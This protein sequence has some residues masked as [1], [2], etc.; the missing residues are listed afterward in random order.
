M[1]MVVVS[2]THLQHEKLEIP[3]GDIIV[4][5]G[6]FS[7]S[8]KSSYA[9]FDWYSKL[10]FKYKILVAGNHDFIFYNNDSEILE[11][12]LNDDYGII[13]L[14]DKSVTIE[15]IKFHGSP[16]TVKFF[17]FAFMKSDTELKEYWDKIPLDTQV[18][19]THGPQFEV[20][21]RVPGNYGGIKHTGSKT[22][23]YKMRELR[24]LKYHL[25]GH[26]HGETNMKEISNSTQSY[27]SVNAA[28]VYD[29][30]ENRNNQVKV[31]I[32][33]NI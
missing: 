26:I 29:F 17:N 14:Q 4:H 18:L 3:D 22:L 12:K 19:I 24:N 21:D 2:D 8:E 20:L 13:Y 25:F 9:F 32:L 33:I 10:D 27:L 7:G 5:C 28:M 23:K 15:G 1:K 31:P 11:K 30:Y 6:D 16:W